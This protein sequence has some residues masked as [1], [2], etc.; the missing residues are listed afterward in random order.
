MKTRR[1]NLLKT[2]LENTRRAVEETNE[3][4]SHWCKLGKVMDDC[5]ADL[6]TRGEEVFGGDSH[7]R[8][9]E[10]PENSEVVLEHVCRNIGEY[11]DMM[12]DKGCLQEMKT[13]EML[14]ELNHQAD[15]A[16][17]KANLLAI[18]TQV[19]LRRNLYACNACYM[20]VPS[21][22]QCPECQK[23]Y[24]QEYIAKGTQLTVTDYSW[25]YGKLTYTCDE[26]DDKGSLVRDKVALHAEWLEEC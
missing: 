22:P 20:I 1:E 18:G 26:Y 17:D 5:I 19:K 8:T 23:G 7:Y 2:L 4:Y 3:N 15:I 24:A 13:Q 16:A 11:V 6:E 25:D 21:G 10:D 14:D 9:D 12:D